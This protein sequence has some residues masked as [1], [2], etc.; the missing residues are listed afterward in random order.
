MGDGN[1]RKEEALRRIQGA[2]VQQ[3]NLAYE[4]LFQHRKKMGNPS[5]VMELHESYS[6]DLNPACGDAQ[7]GMKISVELCSYHF[8]NSMSLESTTLLI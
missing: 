2:S 3:V 7:V 1:Q 4:K 6:K 5:K 8:N